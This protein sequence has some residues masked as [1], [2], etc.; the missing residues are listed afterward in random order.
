MALQPPPE[1]ATLL[2]LVVSWPLIDEVVLHEAGTRWISFAATAVRI[3][4]TAATHAAR[5]TQRNDGEGVRAFG[6]DWSDSSA[7]SGDA[8][9]AALVIGGAL[10]LAAMIVLAMKGR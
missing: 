8:V 3:S 5:T 6:G 4:T 10:Q 1:L 2:N 7:R 9:T